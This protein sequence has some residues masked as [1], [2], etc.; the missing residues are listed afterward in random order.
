MHRNT[1]IN[2]LIADQPGV[3]SR[4]GAVFCRAVTVWKAIWNQHDREPGGEMPTADLRDSHRDCSP[5]NLWA[6]VPDISEPEKR[7]LTIC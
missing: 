3:C 5:E 2:S 7:D 4:P 1:F 6:V